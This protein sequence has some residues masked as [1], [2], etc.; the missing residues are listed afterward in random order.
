[1]E[2]HTSLQEAR[3]EARARGWSYHSSCGWFCSRCPAPELTK[4]QADA[5]SAEEVRKEEKAIRLR[6]R[7]ERR[8][9]MAMNKRAKESQIKSHETPH[10]EPSYGPV[11]VQIG[12]IK[13]Y[14]GPPNSS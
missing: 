8:R 9:V 2:V 1:M 14:T 13:D 12:D 11:R 4:K 5:I 7:D 3:R 6:A 10:R